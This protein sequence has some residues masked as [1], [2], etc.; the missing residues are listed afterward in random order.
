MTAKRNIRCWSVK[1]LGAQGALKFGSWAQMLDHLAV[2]KSSI[3]Q[4]FSITIMN[5]HGRHQ[6]TRNGPGMG[7]T[8][9]RN[10]DALYWEELATQ[11]SYGRISQERVWANVSYLFGR[12]RRKHVWCTI[13]LCTILIETFQRQPVPLQIQDLETE[14]AP[15]AK[16]DT[17]GGSHGAAN[18]V[19]SMSRDDFSWS[20]C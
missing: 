1:S 14:E 4:Y 13:L 3:P 6:K 15:K 2:F 10:C 18:R 19:V 5:T 16:G 11:A 8:S 7:R 9:R 20:V 12:M 17:S